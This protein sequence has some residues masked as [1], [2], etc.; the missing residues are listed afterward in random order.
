MRALGDR[1]GSRVS[2]ARPRARLGRA[3]ERVDRPRLADGVLAPRS[4]SARPSIAS[5]RFSSSSRYES[6][7]SRTISSRRRHAGAR[8]RACVRARDRRGRASPRSPTTSSSS[9]SRRTKPQSNCAR[10][11]PGKRI[12]AGEEDV[13]PPLGPVELLA[14]DGLWLAREEARPADAVAAHV[15]ERAAVEIGGQAHVLGVAE[16]EAEG[17]ADDPRLPIAPPSTS[18][19]SFAVCGLWRYMKASDRSRPPARRRRTH[20]PPPQAAGR[21]GFSQSTCLPASSDRI[22]HSTC[23]EFGSEM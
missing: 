17:G 7:G 13:E 15:H 5:L 1:A 22:D 11:S 12:V 14:V 2:R 4:G 21:S 6:T 3:V 10:T 9:R 23:S 16:A 8:S 18:S 19:F 20:A